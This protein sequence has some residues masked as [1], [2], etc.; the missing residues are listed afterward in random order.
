MAY[1]T[2]LFL[3]SFLLPCCHYVYLQLGL[4]DGP[5]TDLLHVDMDVMDWKTMLGFREVHS[6]FT[7]Q[8]VQTLKLQL[9]CYSIFKSY[10]FPEFV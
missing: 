10:S 3:I 4:H 5:S 7:C 1:C 2:F 6:A 8:I 9:M